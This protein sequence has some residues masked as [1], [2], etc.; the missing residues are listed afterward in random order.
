MSF[1]QRLV[2]A[3]KKKGFSQEEVANKLGTKSPVVGRYERNISKPSIEVA[4]N[5]AALLEVS[6]DFLVGNSKIEMDTNTINRVIE[7]QQLPTEVRDK[8]YYFIDMSFRDF[9]AKQ[10]HAL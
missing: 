3:R 8:L 1:G 2:D 5:L 10:A 4:A 7:L 6:L 9:K